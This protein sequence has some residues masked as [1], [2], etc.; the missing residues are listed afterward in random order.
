MLVRRPERRNS[1]RARGEL[2]DRWRAPREAGWLA[3]LAHRGAHAAIRLCLRPELS[4]ADRLPTEGPALLISNHPSYLDP[5]IIFGWLSHR[6]RVR[7]MAWDMLWRVP[8]IRWYLDAFG[9]FPVNLGRADVDSYRQANR[10]LAAGEVVGVFPE[11]QRARYSGFKPSKRGAI[12]LAIRQRVPLIPV[13]IAGTRAAWPRHHLFPRPGR[14]RV[15]L[16]EPLPPPEPAR[17]AAR[18]AQEWDVLRRLHAA[19]NSELVRLGDI[20]QPAPLHDDVPR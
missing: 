1:R 20:D 11:G 6:R 2:I 17:G 12:R 8:L 13:A 10:L 15:S 19:I 7:F 9:A 14:V 16:L 18:E 4:G 3:T 5:P